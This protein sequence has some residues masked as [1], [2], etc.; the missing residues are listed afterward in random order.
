MAL[1]PQPCPTT[2]SKSY[3]MS[4]LSK[5]APTR[6]ILKMDARGDRPRMVVAGRAQTFEPFAG[7]R[8]YIRVN[9]RLVE[10][11]LRRLPRRMRYRVLDIAA[12]SGMMT[13]LVSSAARA[14]GAEIESLVVD[15]DLGALR[16]ARAEL[17]P[18]AARGY[19]CASAD[20]L[21]L[22]EGFDMVVFANSLH[23]LDDPAKAD[24]VAEVS[25]VLRPGGVLAVNSAFYRGAAPDES[26]AFYGRWIRRAI[27]EMNRARP[28]RAKSDRGPSMQALGPQDYEELITCAGLR[29]LEVR[30]RRVLLSQAAVRAISGYQEFAMG[31]LRATSEDADEAARALE[32]TVQQAF[33][34]LNMRYLPRN[35]LEI[36]AVKR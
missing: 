32:A 20:H 30:E 7:Q 33:R 35:W 12:G 31:A 25:R 29:V 8:A 18:H 10:R 36:I 11:A 24:S 16:E 2:Q 14:V 13:R 34:D 4:N 15:M 5:G 27:V 1:T 22:G 23:L 9:E 6:K 19:V 17:W 26:R 3:A 21:P 28:Q